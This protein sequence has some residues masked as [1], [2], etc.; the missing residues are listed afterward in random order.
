M[1][2]S[3]IICF[4]SVILMF[5]MRAESQSFPDAMKQIFGGAYKGYQWLNY[6]IDNFGVGTAYNDSKEKAD[7]KKFLC[8]TFTCLDISPIPNDNQVWL[9][10]TKGQDHYADFGCGGQADQA[11]TGHSSTAIKAIVPV[12][13]KVVGLEGSWDQNAAGT[14]TLAVSK[15]CD[16]RLLPGPYNLFIKGLN[17]DT[18]GLRD[19]QSHKRLIVVRDDIVI[20]SFEV[21]VSKNSA[22]HTALDG[23]F[24]GSASQVLGDKA[25]IS[26]EV[27][28]DNSG[29]Y[30]LRNTSPLIVGVTAVRQPNTAGAAPGVL[31]TWNG[32][33]K[34]DVPIPP[35]K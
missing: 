22:L 21:I 25:D 18:Y 15:A 9:N 2:K 1:R 4:A 32:W 14:V 7:P 17:K 23:K 24:Q 12:L 27:S 31:P 13:L 11:L 26:V 28:R 20:Q 19:A 33:N 34:T 6:P 35:Q 10:V 30:H 16:R 5:A 3:Q 29:Q 8:A